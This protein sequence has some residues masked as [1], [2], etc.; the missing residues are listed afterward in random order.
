[1]E[2]EQPRVGRLVAAHLAPHQLPAQLS[3]VGEGDVPLQLVL[4]RE[5]PFQEW[6]FNVTLA[7]KLPGGATM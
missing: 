5:T 3:S 6:S 1:M 4:G 2:L 7:N